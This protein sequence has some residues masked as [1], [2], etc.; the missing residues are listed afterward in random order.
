[1]TSEAT[2]LHA[3][4]SRVRLAPVLATL[5]ALLAAAVVASGLTHGVKSSGGFLAYALAIV[6]LGASA[7]GLWRRSS[8]AQYGAWALALAAVGALYAFRQMHVSPRAEAANVALNYTALAAAVIPAVAW[9]RVATP[10]KALLLGGSLA[11]ALIGWE[12]YALVQSLQ[13][14]DE[15]LHDVHWI[16]DGWHHQRHPTMGLVYRPWGWMK[17]WYPTNVRDYFEIEAPSDVLDM[18]SFRLQVED[19]A[20]ALLSRPE[21]RDQPVT[22]AYRAASSEARPPVAIYAIPA[23]V[24]G[25][26]YALSLQARSPARQRLRVEIAQTDHQQYKILTHAEWALTTEWQ[27]LALATQAVDFGGEMHLKLVPMAPESRLEFQDIRV[28]GPSQQP[29]HGDRY[30]VSYA[31][32]GEGFRDRDWSPDAP[33]GVTRIAMLG[34][35]FTVGYGVHAWDLASRRLE[36]ELNSAGD[37]RVEVMNF[38]TVGFSSRQERACFEASIVKHHPQIVLLMMVANDPVS[39]EEENDMGSAHLFKKMEQSSGLTREAYRR[40]W[41]AIEAIKQQYDEK[42]VPEIRALADGCR[43]IGCQLLVVYYRFSDEPN[44]RKM[45]QDIDRALA[46]S[47]IPTH[48]LYAA[49]RAEHDAEALKVHPLDAHPNEIANRLAAD[50]LANK[51]RTLGWLDSAA[52]EPAERADETSPAEPSASTSAAP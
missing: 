35:S 5:G 32:N 37:R 30:S 19:G 38:A 33:P 22:L 40:R 6:A 44:W 52:R 42:C 18:R 50:D 10:A 27:P 34:D 1:M 29:A 36:N 43:R 51:L 48:D 24:P 21:R 41:E 8:V 2:R 26:K 25:A 49:L 3:F 45:V 16:G 39:M 28:S 13:I 31:F 4:E 46:G 11:A 14:K 23:V 17:A 9:L 12:W 20:E 7:G 47:E 15:T